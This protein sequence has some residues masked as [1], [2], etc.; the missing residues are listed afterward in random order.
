MS[1]NNSVKINSL[2]SKMKDLSDYLR[3]SVLD[4]AGEEKQEIIS[5]AQ[6]E[7]DLIVENAKKEAAKIIKNAQAESDSIKAKTDSALNIAARQTVDTLKAAL[8]KEVL[9]ASVNKPV[10]EAL[11]SDEIIKSFIAEVLKIYSSNE[12]TYELALSDEMKEKLNDYLAESI[13]KVSQN[14]IKLSADNLSSGFAVSVEGSGLKFDFSEESVVELL[15]EYI[16]PE[17][18]NML[19][20]K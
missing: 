12:N 20:T 8:E 7:A 17:L 15:T 16:R 10:K 18:R 3:K 5:G 19:F 11:K 13:G 9:A 2:D 1:E 4:P 14:G 6:N